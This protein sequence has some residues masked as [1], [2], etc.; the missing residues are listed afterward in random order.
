MTKDN[1]SVYRDV[2]RTIDQRVEDLLAQMTLEEKLAQLGSAWVYQVMPFEEKAS[3]ILGHGIGHITRIGGASNLLPLEAT[4]LANRIQRYLLEETRLGIPAIVHEECCSGYMARGATCFPQ[5]IALAST[6]DPELAGRMAGVIREQMRAAGGHQGLSPVLD[7]TRDPRWGRTEETFG[8]DPLLVAAMGVAYV[9]GLQG[10][11]WD[12]RVVA[13]LK[14]FAAHGMPDGG[15]N[16]NP[17][18]VPER[19]LREVFLLPF[20]AAVKEAGALSVMPAYHELDG[21]PCSASQELLTDILREQWGFDGTVVSD[22]VAIEQLR[23]PHYV[24]D[25]KSDAAVAALEAGIDIELPGTDCY[26]DPLREAL[27]QELIDIALIDKSVR[28]LLRMKF[29]L[30]LFENP[31]VDA[32]QVVASLD[33]PEHR[34]LAR[35]IAGKGIVLLKNEGD[36][37]PLSQEIESIAVIGPNANSAR[38]LLGDYAFPCHIETLIEMLEDNPLHHAL[39]DPKLLQTNDIGIEVRPILEVLR[40]RLSS[41]TQIHYAQGCEVNSDSRVGFDEAVKAAGQAQVAL[42]FLGD[43]SGLINACTSGETRDRVSIDL[44]G[45]QQELLEA[46]YAT[47]TPVVVVLNTGRPVGVPWMDEHVPAILEMW[48]PGEEGAEAIADV[49]FGDV[50]P[51]GKLPITFPRHVGQIPTFY[52]HKPSGGRSHWKGPYVSFSNKPLYPF[53]YGLS[54]TKFELRNFRLGRDQMQAGESV[55]IQVDVT[56]VGSR[57]GDEVVQL[58]IR[59]EIATVARPVKELKGF[60]R[61]H[62]AAGETKTV[63]FTLYADQL[64]FY[65][66]E[67]KFVVEPG[68]VQ[69]MVG[70]SSEDLP[71]TAPVEIMG[72]VTEISDKIFFS[73]SIVKS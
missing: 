32:G 45:V 12:N 65:N 35:E 13:T 8:E 69:I 38:H 71:F 61:V 30:G 34:A 51:G 23:V 1:S 41:K 3:E 25:T 19:E 18:H 59:D 50:N 47:G 4:E 68:T 20:E 66:R 54:Y 73:M 39:P 24:A 64:A 48:Q 62:L 57:D 27:E 42:L 49:L 72:N 70:T 10:E 43:R 58:Y 52:Y 56:N 7:I 17:V 9:R 67:M 53:G 55:T 22:Y 36:L 6:W 15:M 16:Q 14:H 21:I 28:R 29:Q 33:M 11:D 26:G 63:T 5:A 37:L 46:V 44:P 40:D 60:R 2:S 31:Y